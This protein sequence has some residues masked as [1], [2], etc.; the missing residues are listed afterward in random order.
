MVLAAYLLLT[1]ALIV[2]FHAH[3]AGWPVHL[4]V[5]LAGAAGLWAL[6]RTARPLPRAVE[7]ARRLLPLAVG[8][9]LYGEVAA[10]NDL[11]FGSRYFDGPVM[12]W[13]MALFGAQMAAHLRELLPSRALSEFLHFAYFSYYLIPV[14]LWV[15]LAV[16]RRF[17]AL[18]EYLTA[19]GLTFVASMTWFVLFPVAGPFYTLVPP[20]PHA[21]GDVFPPLV[22]RVL[23]ANA[24]QGAAFPS[25]HVAV[26]G[27]VLI[28]AARH[29]RFSFAILAVLVPAL[30]MGAVYGGFHYAVDA[31]AGA[32]WCAACAMV[33]LPLHRR[34]GVRPSAAPARPAAAASAR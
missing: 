9:L 32:V 8:P 11:V 7:V 29:D 6:G 10:L 26:S 13:E 34:L 28:M 16:R 31:V 17:D 12:R 4:A 1:G 18:D 25:S 15:A 23:H 20:D 27:A 5:H 2:P 19:L 14:L 22:H 30:A 21:M 24:S 33:A 3:L